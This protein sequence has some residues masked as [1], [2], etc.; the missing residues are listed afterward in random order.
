[1]L[2]IY[3]VICY[4]FT[5]K[6]IRKM[7]WW[8]YKTHIPSKH[9]SLYGRSHS[10]QG[11]VSKVPVGAGP[12]ILQGLACWGH[13]QT[14]QPVCTIVLPLFW[15]LIKFWHQKKMLACAWSTQKYETISMFSIKPRWYEPNSLIHWHTRFFSLFLHKLFTLIVST[16]TA[17]K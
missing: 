2:Y 14:A 9:F 17:H 15:T 4:F 5:A 10:A 3:I 1:M 11:T 8:W 12:H 16:T 13:P 6:Y 7:I